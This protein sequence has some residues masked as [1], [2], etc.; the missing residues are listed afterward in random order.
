MI[1]KKEARRVEQKL[2]ELSF[3]VNAIDV[4]LTHEHILIAPRDIQY[5]EV[6]HQIMWDMK[7]EQLKKE[8]K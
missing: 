7:F 6:E 4:L 5:L 2:E 1:G 8:A 3:I